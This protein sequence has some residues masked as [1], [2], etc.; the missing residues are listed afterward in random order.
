MLPPPDLF[1]GIIQI[2]SNA[3]PWTLASYTADQYVISSF[4]ST[5]GHYY[6]KA[7]ITGGTSCWV[8]SDVI[9]L[10]V[11]DVP[12]PPPTIGHYNSANMYYTNRKSDIK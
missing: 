9:D 11:N 4:Y 12:L 6:F 3:G 10:T 5:P 7:R 1:N 8:E 2:V